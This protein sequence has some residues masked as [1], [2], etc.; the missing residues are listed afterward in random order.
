LERIDAGFG[1]R[2]PRDAPAPHLTRRYSSLAVRGEQRG[3]GGRGGGAHRRWGRGGEARRRW[4]RRGARAVG[5]RR[6]RRRA[7][8]AG[9]E[10]AEA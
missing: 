3:R 6:G 5:K 8:G 2:R 1:I 4:G 9:E 7:V 10:G